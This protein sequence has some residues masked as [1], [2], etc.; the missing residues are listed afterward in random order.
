VSRGHKTCPKCQIEVGPRTKI[1]PQCKHEFVF[2]PG[3][4]PSRKTRNRAVPVEKPFEALTENPS[5]IIGV[6]DREALDS[7]ITQLQSCR[8]DSNR[9]GGCY[10]AFLHHK[11]GTLQVE[12]WFTMEL[13]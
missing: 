1:C 8:A 10:S 12:I 7:F 2:G 11:H 5:E 6:N 9:G 13:P 4:A 3:K